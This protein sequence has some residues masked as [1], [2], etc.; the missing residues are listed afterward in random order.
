MAEEIY[1]LKDN[2][3]NAEKLSSLQKEQKSRQ[4]HFAKSYFLG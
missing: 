3:E 1:N 4:A 2:M